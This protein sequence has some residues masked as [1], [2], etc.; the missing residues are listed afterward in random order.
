M[1]MPDDKPLQLLS[2]SGVDEQHP[3]EIQLEKSTDVFLAMHVYAKGKK[4]K[5]LAA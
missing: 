3:G 1:I 2:M 5:R 4:E